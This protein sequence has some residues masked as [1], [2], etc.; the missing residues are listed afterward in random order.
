LIHIEADNNNN[1][2]IIII[3]SLSGL[4]GITELF[5]L[6]SPVSVTLCLLL[7]LWSLYPYGLPARYAAGPTISV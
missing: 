3:I 7:L 4:N 5:L 2:N 1:N 6:Y